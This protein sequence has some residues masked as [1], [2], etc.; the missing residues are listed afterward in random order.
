MS[1]LRETIAMVREVGP[2]SAG[3]RAVWRVAPGADFDCSIA[4]LTRT[5]TRSFADAVRNEKEIRFARPDDVDLLASARRASPHGKPKE[6][7]EDR[8]RR[9]VVTSVLERNGELVGYCCQWAG[10]Y[11][12]R[13]WIR[14]LPSPGDTWT[15]DIWVVPGERG[16][17]IHGRLKRFAL[18][19]R[20]EAGYVRALAMIEFSNKRSLRASAKSG[21]KRL[22]LILY[23]RLLRF[24]LVRARGVLRLGRWSEVRPLTL[25][26]DALLG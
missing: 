15:I 21:G 8:F 12:H 7:W 6:V 11:R 5:D 18:A 24:T 25:P 17:D 14:Y 9:G 3:V 26:V 20:V 4:W 13:K 2:L 23:V 10:E 16:R 19:E 1:L 22:G